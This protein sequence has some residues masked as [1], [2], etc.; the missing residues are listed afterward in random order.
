MAKATDKISLGIN[1]KLY[2]AATKL[3]AKLFEQIKVIDAIA[4]K[5]IGGA[6]IDDY[7]AL[8]TNP[9]EYLSELYWA[10]YGDKFPD[11]SD[12]KATYLRQST[13][14]VSQIL[15]ITDAINEAILKLRDHRPIIDGSS[16]KSG[17]KESSFNTYVHKSKEESYK[18]I[19]CILRDH[20]KLADMNKHINQ[21]FHL[22]RCYAPLINQRGG[23][24]R[25]N[26]QYF[27]QS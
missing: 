26:K 23:I 18:L 20:Q 25:P 9:I 10:K 24:V 19:K 22:V 6:A 1:V 7:N 14:S 17:L 16:I 11:N 21:D 5:S 8:L 12:R 3:D 27:Q 2:E 15:S 13:F 4:E